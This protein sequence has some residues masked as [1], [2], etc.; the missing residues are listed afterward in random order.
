MAETP[1]R[2]RGLVYHLIE[3]D[4]ALRAAGRPISADSVGNV[5]RR[6][7]LLLPDEFLDQ[8]RRALE[9]V[10]LGERNLPAEVVR[11]ILDVTASMDDVLR[12]MS[13]PRLDVKDL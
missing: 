5:A 2:L 11:L 9:E 7:N 10:L 4:D 12:E 1:R 8:G 6:F 3:V 13:G